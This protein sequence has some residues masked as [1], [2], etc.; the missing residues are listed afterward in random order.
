MTNFLTLMC[1]LGLLA[2]AFA[3][4]RHGSNT[5]SFVELGSAASAAVSPSGA[6]IVVG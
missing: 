1:A 3:F 5:V 4:A 2:G 6:A